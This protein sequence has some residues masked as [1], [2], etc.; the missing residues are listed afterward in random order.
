MYT[1]DDLCRAILAPALDAFKSGQVQTYVLC[2]D[3]PS[4]VPREKEPEQKRRSEPRRA[5]RRFAATHPEEAAALDTKRRKP[6]SRILTPSAQ[7][8]K[9][10]QAALKRIYPPDAILVAEGIQY[11]PLMLDGT[12]DVT[13][14]EPLHLPSLLS[15]RVA[16]K[17]IW[18]YL[19][20]YLTRTVRCFHLS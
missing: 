18:D 5:E 20:T 14:T 7:R 1:G 9:D 16:R 15:E 11:R 10:D 4:R 13:F 12:R 2:A 6:S 19:V 3:E 8:R 17:Q